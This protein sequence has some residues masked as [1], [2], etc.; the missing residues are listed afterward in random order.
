MGETKP[1]GLTDAICYQCWLGA[2]EH[3]KWGMHFD[4]AFCTKTALWGS[5]GISQGEA[6]PRWMLT[7]AVQRLL[8]TSHHPAPH[9]VIPL[10]MQAHLAEHNLS[11]VGQ[12]SYA[13]AAHTHKQTLIK[14]A[15]AGSGCVL[16]RSHDLQLNTP[17]VA[18]YSQCGFGGWL[19]VLQWMQAE[20][21]LPCPQMA[22]AS[23]WRV[24]MQ[25]T[26]MR[27]QL[28]RQQVW[29][30]GTRHLTAGLMTAAAI[31]RRHSCRSASTPRRLSQTQVQ[32]D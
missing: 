2:C 17:M 1:H 4:R 9:Q 23:E 29:Q 3:H 15:V 14:H 19:P 32:S 24:M 11:C 8:Q 5:Q 7:V 21:S 10:P 18:C 30:R 26:Q 13:A 28:A 6:H 27:W 22:A 16:V 20:Q 25:K 31:L 12:G